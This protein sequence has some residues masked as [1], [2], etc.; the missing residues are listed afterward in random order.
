[1]AEL[2]SDRLEEAP[3]FTY[4]GIDVFGPW[5]ITT[6]RTRGGQANSKRWAELFTYLCIRAIHIEVIEELSLSAFINALHRFVAIRGK[7]KQFRS[8][9]GTNFV[10]STD[11]LQKDAI[12]VEDEHVKKYLY[13]TGTVWVFN[14][15]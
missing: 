3:P 9:R 15:P 11:D 13:D 5:S 1:M 14:T 10:G 4:V 6:R 12:N 7:V 2:P 8:E